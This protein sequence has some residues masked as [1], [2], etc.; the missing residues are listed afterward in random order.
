MLGLGDHKGF[1]LGLVVEL[2][3]GALIGAESGPA[4]KYGRKDGTF[5]LALRPQ[6]FGSN[7]FADHVSALC[8]T[9]AQSA[10]RQEN[11]IIRTPGV[12]YARLRAQ[13]PWAES[14]EVPDAAWKELLD[15]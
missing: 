5:L 2:L 4:R 6:S 8:K 10:P 1:G 11:A 14:I 13:I 12:A 7:T 9:I 3:A 15:M